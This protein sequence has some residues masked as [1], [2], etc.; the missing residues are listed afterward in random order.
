[1]KLSLVFKNILLQTVDRLC[2]SK[3]TGR[4]KTLG[5][6]EALDCIF[7]VLRTGMQWREIEASVSYATVHRRMTA[8]NER[9]VFENAYKKALATYKKL[10][11]TTRYCIDS[12]YVKNRFGQEC[13]GRNHTDRGR[14]ALKLSAIVDQHGMPHGLACHPGN[15]PDVV[16]F[17]PCLRNML[18]HLESVPM[19][20]D[21]GYDSRHNRSVCASH[22][23]QD[24][25]FRRK[26]K[27]VRRTNAKRIVVEHLFA[28]MGRYRRLLLYY[29]QRPGTFLAFVFLAFGH[30]MSERFCRNG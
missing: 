17:E 8:W 15:K 27:T 11:P 18:T 21:R 12:T 2:P 22:G 14:K 24:R 26:V 6:E 1:M 13:V 19:Y 30:L 4:P 16:L 9:G 28:W 29:E 23:L 25:I 5:D 20:A 3:R 10:N 7:K